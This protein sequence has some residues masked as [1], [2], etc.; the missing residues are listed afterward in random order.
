M[1]LLL[2]VI[3]ADD[4]K[5]TGVIKKNGFRMCSVLFPSK[6]TQDEESAK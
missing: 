1:R 4:Q 6:P 5:N 2:H 3:L